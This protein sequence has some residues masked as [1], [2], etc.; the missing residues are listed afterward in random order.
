MH[1]KIADEFGTLLTKKEAS[2][3]LRI[4]IRTLETLLSKD[5]IPTIRVGRSVRIAES[6]LRNYLTNNRRG[7]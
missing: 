4:N 6:D 1:E 2:E 3:R 7:N 5:A